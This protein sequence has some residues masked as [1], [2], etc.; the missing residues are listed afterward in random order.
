MGQIN[1]VDDNHFNNQVLEANKPV[2]VDFWAPWCGPCK[3]IAPALEALAAQYADKIKVFKMNVDDNQETPAQYGVR[4]IPTLMLFK[5]G[6]VLATQ[7]GALTQVQLAAF[8]DA[9]IKD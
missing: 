8:I 7:V 1:A 9:H 5:D 4:G 6:E 2:L 3:A